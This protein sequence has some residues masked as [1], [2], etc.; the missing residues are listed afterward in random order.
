MQSRL[1]REYKFKFYLNS[2]HS[3]LIDG[4]QGAVHPHT[5]E[6]TLR[7]L[8]QKEGFVEF[9]VFEKASNLFFEKYQNQTLNNVKPFDTLM[10]TLENMVDYFGE[11]L[12]SIIR[13]V[14]GELMEI[15]GSETPTRSYLV[16]YEKDSEFLE[17]IEM[18]TQKT[19]SR[20]MESFLDGIED[21]SEIED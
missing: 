3:I 2:G 5:W 21:D 17:H 6:F 19:I 10:P 14:G 13:A 15:E 18:S 4:H 11:Q 20:I 9:N 16:S 7:I 8:I 1:Y 12:R